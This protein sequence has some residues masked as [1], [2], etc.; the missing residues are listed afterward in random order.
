MRRASPLSL[1][2]SSLVPLPSPLSPLPSPRPRSVTHT[3]DHPFDLYCAQLACQHPHSRLHPHVGHA[4]LSLAACPP[5]ASQEDPNHYTN[6]KATRDAP[7]PRFL[8][9]YAPPE[10]SKTAIF[11]F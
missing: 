7:M 5:H 6:I 10:V 11:S 4:P 2:P 3:D 9:T 1:L 8:R